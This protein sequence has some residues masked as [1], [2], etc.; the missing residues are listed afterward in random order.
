M[1]SLAF[2]GNYKRIRSQY[3][4][5]REEPKPVQKTAVIQKRPLFYSCEIGPIKPVWF[6]EYRRVRESM[7]Q[8]DFARHK[9]EQIIKEVCNKHNVSRVDLISERRPQPLVRA[10]QEAYYRLATEMTWS[11]PRIGRFLG[12]RDHTTILH[13]K[14]Q[15]E[16]RL[17]SGEAAL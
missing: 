13:G 10:R 16:A 17:A 15:F 2:L 5:K 7:R 6:D 11:L 3:F 12:G 14:R 8:M 9:A 1:T 4:E